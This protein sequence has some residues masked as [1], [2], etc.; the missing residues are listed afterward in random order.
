MKIT[1]A[2]VLP[3]VLMAVFALTRWPG[4][5]PQQWSSFSAAY[6]LAFCAGVYFPRALAWSLPIGTLLISDVAMNI[7]Y[8]KVEPLSRYMLMNYLMYAALIWLGQRYSKNDSLAKLVGGGIWGALLFFIITNVIAWLQNPEYTKDWN[9]FMQAWTTGIAGWP[10]PW[11]FLRNTLLS[12]G[13][14]TGLF[15]G[16]MK[17]SEAA[18]SAREKEVPKPAE[19]EEPEPAPQESKA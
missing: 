10:P 19:E 17:L 13:L 14:F 9:G 15:A 6:A 1:W 2:K 8:Y 11:M 3:F 12:G 16:A 5:L 4:L 7:F 18:E